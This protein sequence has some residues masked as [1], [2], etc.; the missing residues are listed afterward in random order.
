MGANY[1]FAGMA[2]T[3]DPDSMYLVRR[4]ATTANW[5]LERYAYDDPYW[6]LAQSV[7]DED[8]RTY[9]EIFRPMVPV[10]ARA[11]IPV[12]TLRGE[13]ASYGTTANHTQFETDVAFD[14][15]QVPGFSGT[16]LYEQSFAG[17]SPSASVP[18][19]EVLTKSSGVTNETFT[20]QADGA[21]FGGT[22]GRFRHQAQAAT[23]WGIENLLAEDTLMRADLRIAIGSVGAYGL[24][25]RWLNSD[26]R[27]EFDVD[28]TVSAVKIKERVGGTTSESSTTFP[29]LSAG[30]GVTLEFLVQGTTARGRIYRNGI[31]LA[32]VTRSLTGPVASGQVGI[33][34]SGNPAQAVTEVHAQRVLVIEP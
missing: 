23:L 10:D 18:D 8:W 27:I 2:A 31:I 26:N 9:K 11:E 25:S 15:S 13:Y 7:H 6:V 3:S 19:W 14:F 17:V 29:T 24:I 5:V 4:D 32:E 33:K 34:A 12:T 22:Y 16:V 20:A 21:Y 1:Y 30:T 28:F